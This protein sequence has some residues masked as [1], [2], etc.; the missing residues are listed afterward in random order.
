MPELPE[1]ETVVRGLVHHGLVGSSITRARVFW[2]RTVAGL[3]PQAF[4]KRLS[5][6]TVKSVSR[7]AKYIVIALDNADTILIH[8][9]MTGRI[10]LNQSGSRRTP[11]EHVILNFSDGRQLRF[12]DTRK[13]GRWVVTTK[14]EIH[15]AKIG[16]E[17][18]S[19][20]FTSKWLEEALKRHRRMLKPLLLDQ[21]FVAGLGNIYVDEALWAAKLHPERLSDSI[22]KQEAGNLRQAIVK[23]LRTGVEN[24]G[25]SL[26][27]A[28]TNFYSVAKRRGRNQDKLKVFR[29]DGEKCPRCKAVIAREV[30]A[31]RSSHFCPV[32]QK[33]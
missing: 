1:V 11:H 15:L 19:K 21:T 31:Q 2:P 33:L 13:F 17:P 23:V 29:R 25:T 20:T 24:M 9:R 22:S 10:D 14:P 8:L 5:G 7:R 32:C 4:A 27:Q 12:H 3:T 28:N 26:G 16:P 30:I 18:F 6:R